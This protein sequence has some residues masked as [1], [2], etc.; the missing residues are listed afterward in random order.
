MTFH[1]LVTESKNEQWVLRV[2]FLGEQSA[3]ESCLH[4]IP[5]FFYS[6]LCIHRGRKT[7]RAGR[8]RKN[9]ISSERKKLGELPACCV[10]RPTQAK[11]RHA[12][13]RGGGYVCACL[14]YGAV[15]IRPL[16]LVFLDL[17]LCVCVSFLCQVSSLCLDQPGQSGSPLSTLR[18]NTHIYQNTAQQQKEGSRGREVLGIGAE[19]RLDKNRE[20]YVRENRNTR[21]NRKVDKQRLLDRRR[22]DGCRLS[23]SSK[24]GWEYRVSLWPSLW[25]QR[26]GE[27]VEGYKKKWQTE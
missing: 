21:G 24:G 12:G 18:P 3:A 26:E 14:Q 23:I 16:Q 5:A 10:L 27:R 4:G 22:L 11:F 9:E 8:D 1:L 6:E 20:V 17:C 7:A 2:T 15:R 13:G 25:L 19:G